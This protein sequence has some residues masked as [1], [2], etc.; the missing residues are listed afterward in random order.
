MRRLMLLLTLTAFGVSVLF[1]TTAGAAGYWEKMKDRKQKAAAAA[2]A[3]KKDTEK[4]FNEVI[5]GFDKVSGLFDFYVNKKDL[6]TFMAI[7]P[8]QLGKQYM[9]NITRTA[10]DGTYAEGG[11]QRDEF[12]F[13]LRQVGKRVQFIQTNVR[14]RADSSANLAKSL[15]RSISQ[16]IFG[17]TNVASA[18]DT[19]GAVLID[20]SSIMVADVD[21]LG[22]YLGSEGKTGFRM[23]RENSNFGTIKSFPLNSEIDV[24]LHYKSDKPNSGMTLTSPYSFFLTYHYSLSALP[25]GSYRPRLADDRIGFF[26]TVY[27]DYT[28]LATE[29]PYVRFINRWNLEKKDPT[30]ALSEPKEPIVFWLENTTPVEYRDALRDGVLS[31][32]KAFEAAG[33]KNAIVVKQMPD[34]ADWDPADVRFNVIR[35]I[36]WPTQTYGAI[37]PSRVNPYTGQ[38]YDADI[39]VVANT[40]RNVFGYADNFIEPAK[41][42]G[43]DQGPFDVDVK[44]LPTGERNWETVCDYAGSTAEAVEAG[45][46]VLQTRDSFEGKAELTQKYVKEYLH[47]M[48][49]HEVGHTLGLRHNFKAS[50]V[51]TQAQLSDPAFV[52]K[53]G[54]VNTV[55]EYTPPNIAAL[56]KPQPDFFNTEVGPFDVWS[57]QYGYSP[58]NASDS[59]GEKPELDKIASRAS[60]PLLAYGTDEDCFGNTSRAI[61]PYVTQGDL[62][63]DPIEFWKR[64]IDLSHELWSKVE[65]EFETPGQNYRKLRTVFAYGWSSFGLAGNNVARFIG[66]IQNNRDHVGDPNGRL[67]FVPV[68]AAKQREAMKFL[69]DNLWSADAF[70]FSPEFLNKLQSEKYADFTGS[71]WSTQ[72]IDYPVHDQV[73]AVQRT[74]F[75]HIYNPITLA[76]LCDLELRYDKGQDVYTM[77][78]VFQDVR[79]AI[80][81]EV[82]AGKNVSSMR[83]NLQRAHLDILV[84]LVTNTQLPV[85]EDAKTLARVD[86]RALKSA[87]GSALAAGTLD[88]ITRGHLE[89]SLARINAALDASINLKI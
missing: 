32:N 52:A 17:S 48:I 75:N 26:Q 1:T 57:I 27:Q 22:Y 71:A 62:A 76:R 49:C 66:G 68:P 30:A 21:N 53:N 20:L 29:T 80:W 58:I 74:P 85:P 42:N 18:P 15:P 3:G 9:C 5:K 67:P 36:I 72:R 25:E 77:T 23:D 63:S 6:Q 2:P 47:D 33:F 40:I 14:L 60:D 12:L 87:I 79:R 89:D 19:S 24:V 59:K 4:P 10:G 34:T 69:V 56:G 39:M 88:T 37:G 83:R 8:A 81:S 64:R 54:V 50:T 61:D 16:A 28:D 86:L 70:K 41:A 51:Y 82:I 13:E 44:D 11:L 7:K 38:I 46:A 78:Q 84:D 55:M 45:L 65:K 43:K 31:W 35:W 73:L